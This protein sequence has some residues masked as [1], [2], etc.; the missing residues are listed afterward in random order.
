MCAPLRDRPPYFLQN[1]LPEADSFNTLRSNTTMGWVYRVPA[2]RINISALGALERP[3]LAWMAERLPRSLTPDHLTVVGIGGALIAS[4]GYFASRWSLQWL[5]VASAGL[6]VNWAGDSLDGTVARLRE[7]Q[8]PRYGFFVDHTSDLFSQSL[9][10]LT[11]GLSPCAHFS[12]ACLGVIA[13][14]MAFVYSLICVEVRNTLR[15]TYFGFGPTEIRA[16][17]IAGNLIT[18]RAGVF[19]VGVPPRGWFWPVTIYELTIVTLFTI[20]VPALAL[21]ALKERSE[22]ANEDPP[23]I[24]FNDAVG[25]TRR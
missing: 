10:F 18:L 1:I 15:I 21:L 6:A 2:N 25:A 16:L 17:L 4:A 19:D 9:I 23:R 20:T 24:A 22:L 7:I 13:F 5:W 12:I 8:R 3:A 14:L 11:L